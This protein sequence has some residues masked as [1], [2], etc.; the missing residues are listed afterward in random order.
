MRPVPL[1]LLAMPLPTGL[2]SATGQIL[3]RSN[4]GDCLQSPHQR[5]NMRFLKRRPINAAKN[6]LCSIVSVRLSVS[7]LSVY[8]SDKLLESTES[9]LFDRG[10][11][12]PGE[13]LNSSVREDKPVTI[14][15]TRCSSRT[16]PASREHFLRQY[17][18]FFPAACYRQRRRE[19]VPERFRR[20]RRKLL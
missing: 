12:S 13:P 16:H 11:R 2:Q 9:L 17:C 15:S 4:R 5:D 20:R 7:F 3:R 8:A 1:R 14:H 19:Q 10:S 6:R 18:K